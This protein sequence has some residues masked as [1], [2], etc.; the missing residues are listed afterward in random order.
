MLCRQPTPAVMSKCIVRPSLYR[1]FLLALATVSVSAAAKFDLDRVTPVPTGEP[2]PTMDF[3][4]PAVLSRPV[5]NPSG[6]HVAAVVT[7]AEDK[8]LLLVY[9]LKAPEKF[10]TIGGPGDKDIYQVDW[11]SDSRVMFGLSYQKQYGIGLM[12]ADV[13]SLGSGYAIQ[14]YNNS[15]VISVPLKNRL[16]PLVWNRFDMETDQDT[17][18]SVLDTD[19]QTGLFVDLTRANNPAVRREQFLVPGITTISML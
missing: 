14:Q 9:D 17:G 7:A 10:A 15:R 12:A 16:R 6:T 2:I 11:L 3:F 5:L 8:H 18:V 19:I 13:G 1:A 4:R